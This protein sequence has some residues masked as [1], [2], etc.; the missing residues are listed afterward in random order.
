MATDHAESSEWE[1]TVPWAMIDDLGSAR[2]LSSTL[3]IVTDW[4]PKLIGADRVSMTLIGNDG[5]LN[6]LAVHDQEV[7]TVEVSYALEDSIVG[8]VYSSHQLLNSP[9]I[10][11]ETVDGR[12]LIERGM[13]SCLVAPLIGH[14][15]CYGTFNVAHS[16][17][18]YFTV[19]HERVIGALANLVAS[20]VRVHLQI[21]AEQK[22]GRVDSLTGALNRSG[23]VG[24]LAERFEQPTGRICLLFIDLDGF[25][26]I[27]DTYGHA[28]GDEMLIGLTQRFR[29]AIRSKDVLSRIGGD[30]LSLI[31]I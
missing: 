4:A 9:D 12:M 11:P 22:R 20:F 5:K 25:K 15:K 23:L 17:A 2:N 30:E 10:P 28:V 27:N 8:Q 19:E 18:N 26:T 29:T 31:H 14:D 13:K 7:V 1:S 24:L 6:R 21:L 3:Q 16:K